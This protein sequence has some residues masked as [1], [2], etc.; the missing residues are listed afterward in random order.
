MT[1]DKSLYPF[2]HCCIDTRE[3]DRGRIKHIKDYL[4]SRGCHVTIDTCDYLDYVFWGTFFTKSSGNKKIDLGVSFKTVSDICTSWDAL[5][6]QLYNATEMYD[7]V[8][9]FIHGKIDLS[10]HEG[11]DYVKN[12]VTGKTKVLGERGWEEKEVCL[13][14]LPYTTYQALKWEL[15]DAGI[16]VEQFDRLVQFEK[17][18][19]NMFMFIAN[20]P[21]DLVKPPKK[22]SNA[23]RFNSICQVK[24]IGASH[25]HKIKHQHWKY[26]VENPEELKA[27]V[28]PAAFKRLMEFWGYKTDE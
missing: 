1:K 16:W 3:K 15:G 18:L 7:N 9:L 17:T 8:A 4:E 21:H 19:H 13:E 23:E 10:D 11:T 22:D 5:K 2:M 26:W 27:L 25:A 28:G 12:Y 14:M 24:R 6:G 20:S